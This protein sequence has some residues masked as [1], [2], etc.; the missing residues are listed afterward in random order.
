MNLFLPDKYVEYDKND[1]DAYYEGSA[2]LY[3]EVKGIHFRN[4]DVKMVEKLKRESLMYEDIKQRISDM[5][6]NWVF[7]GL[8]PSD[9]VLAFDNNYYKKTFS[10]KEL[11]VLQSLESYC[12]KFGGATIGVFD[13][14]DVY[15]Y[16]QVKK[17]NDEIKRVANFMKKSKFTPLEALLYA[18]TY[19]KDRIY[20]KE[21]HDDSTSK[22]RSVYG[23]L[24][25]EKIVCVGFSELL[26]AIMKEYGDENVKAFANDVGCYD[27]KDK[28]DPYELHQNNIVYLKD[29]KYKINGFYYLDPTWDNKKKYTKKDE[30][31]IK[32][33]T[34]EKRAYKQKN[35]AYHYFLTEIGQ[36]KNID[37]DIIEVEEAYGK[38]KGEYNPIPFHKRHNEK[39][40]I[41]WPDYTEVSS[42]KFNLQ[43]YLE[44]GVSYI[45]NKELADNTLRSYLFSRN[46]FKEYAILKQTESE[47]GRH[48]KQSVRQFNKI[49]DKNYKKGM[50]DVSLLKII[51]QRKAMWKYLNE[52][53]P[54]IDIG[55]INDAMH[56]VAKKVC[57]NMSKDEISKNIY[58]L[59]KENIL[60]SKDNFKPGAQT[61]LTECENLK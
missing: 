23:I 61:A 17:A 26:K 60:Y 33:F 3:R 59:L 58:T 18:Y 40:G 7:A 20:I 8:K 29:D 48:K 38:A 27:R 51:Y 50:E 1:L 55:P 44:E 42:K 6:D 35:R 45:E 34:P 30:E 43:D 28:E 4:N 54:H 41:T 22:S 13:Y 5:I 39:I 47:F 16:N 15:S 36:I 11:E 53:S 12:K 49:F 46:D 19:V 56:A 9:V 2:V 32:D 14:E 31:R 21:G 57:P 37:V 24:N 10:D 25:S 52:H